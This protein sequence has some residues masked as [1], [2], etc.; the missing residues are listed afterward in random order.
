MTDRASIAS[1]VILLTR[2]GLGSGEPELQRALLGKYLGLLAMMLATCGIMFL[3]LLVALKGF[4]APITEGVFL[5]FL[6][7]FLE[8]A[9]L[10]AFA[11]LCSTFTSSFVSGFMTAAIFV[12]GH[13]SAE[14][15]FYSA[16]SASLAQSDTRAKVYVVRRGDTLSSISRRHRVSVA[17]IMKWNGKR[18][19]H[20]RVGERM[21]IQSPVAN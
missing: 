3:G 12:S 20:I 21:R 10:G 15:K 19:A 11:V 6:G 14:L 2:D 1:T 13:L 18:S 16:K 17:Q 8:V 9:V 7:V 5:G 4:K